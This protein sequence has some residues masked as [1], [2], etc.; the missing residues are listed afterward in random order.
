M[1]ELRVDAL[2]AS[3]ERMKREVGAFFQ[4]VSR[5]RPIVVFLDDLHWADVSTIDILNYLAG[6]FADMRVLV[7]DDLPAG[8]DGARAAPVSRHHEQPA[9]ARPVRRDR[10]RVSG[11]GRCGSLPR[12]GVPR[13]PPSAG[14]LGA[15]SR[16]DRGQPALH[17]RPRALPPRFGR[18]RRG[19]RHLGAGALDVGSAARS[20]RVGPQHDREEDRAGRR[21][22]SRAAPGGERAGTGVRFGRR[23]RSHRA[24]PGRRRRTARRPRARARLRQARQRVR[25]SG[26]DPD[27]ALPVRARA[28][29]EHPLRVAAADAPGD[30]QRTRGAGARRATASTRPRAPHVWPSCSKRRG[31]SRRAP[32][33][34]SPPRS[35]RS[36]SSDSARRSRW[37]IAA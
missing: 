6:R 34:T 12:A 13:T 20:A 24:G 7:A 4:D 27:A 19:Q 10:A 32:S 17:G 16:Q 8:G 22:G 2:S 36:A 9:I 5:A 1:A 15:D 30:A 37:R 14:F 25:V 28:L 31:T 3:Q 21:A 33:T 35:T 11:A 26:P 18:D 29:S 23:E